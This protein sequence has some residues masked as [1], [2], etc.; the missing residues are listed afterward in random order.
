LGLAA[1]TAAFS[2]VYGVMLKPLPF[3]NPDELMALRRGDRWGWETVSFPVFEDLL[4]RQQVF[5]EIGV[6]SSSVR[7]MLLGERPVRMRGAMVSSGLLPALGATP[8]FGR[9]FTEDDDIEN[10][11]GVILLSHSFW[12][13]QFG[14]D[15]D[16]LGQ[17][18]IVNDLPHTV[19]GVMPEGFAFP[20]PGTQFWESL[21]FASRQR[22]QFYLRPVGR[23]KAGISRVAAQDHMAGT[24]WVI[25]PV[26]D[27]PE[28]IVPLQA[29]SLLAYSV[30]DAPTTLWLFQGAAFAVLLI[31]CLNVTSLLLVRAKT[32]ESEVALRAALGA[33]RSRLARFTLTE[34]G[35]LGL[36]GGAIGLVAAY[37]LVRA[38][39]SAIPG[40]IP[41]Q[42]RIAVGLPVI[43]VGL[44]LAVVAGVI[45]GV[46]PAFRTARV[47]LCRGVGGTGKG[48]P[49]GKGGARIWG[50][51]VSAQLALAVILLI[52]GGLLLE[53]FVK[54]RNVD[55]GFNPARVLIANIPISSAGYPDQADRKAFYDELTTRL[56]GLPQI[57]NATVMGQAPFTGWSDGG[58]FVEGASG[59]PED[60]GYTEF[61]RVGPGYFETL[62]IPLLTGRDF[63]KR[64]GMENALVVIV[65]ETLANRH[66]ADGSAL[67][68]RLRRPGD[69]G[70]PWLTIVGVVGDIKHIA[71]EAPSS[72]QVYL[73]YALSDDVFRMPLAI[74]TTGD[75]LAAAGSVRETVAAM[76]PSIPPPTTYS[77]QSDM[78]RTMTD[79]RFNTWILGS[80]AATALLL[81][82]LGVYSVVAYTVTMRSREFGIRK[83]LGATKGRVVRDVVNRSALVIVVGLGVGLAAAF[84]LAGVMESFLFGVQA[85]DPVL[86]G[87]VAVSLGIAAILATYVPARRAGLMDPVDAIRAE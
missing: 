72:P 85:R 51:L 30:R 29:M 71:L 23:L 17:S 57:Q 86:F 41:L 61:Q 69:E 87:I 2:I 26:G 11:P 54:L 63:G 14:G 52:G 5:R 1:T 12:M 18:V 45:I 68:G 4:R 83:A 56:E 16:I 33:G 38:A 59:V 39:L 24:E 73:P 13:N 67:G 78:E 62:D 3:E 47:D 10:A 36:L 22:N 53:S 7:T 79:E 66:F 46:L 35:L 60:V 64:D 58:A 50:V 40:G 25:P 82:M 70:V 6:W 81:A 44:L 19:V 20:T 77:L 75:P 80:F 34:T 21:A 48:Q 42:E 37:G 65:N 84:T 49:V 74:R 31:A 32:R 9:W 43:G 76:D 55:P 28:R 8:S 15:E 27:E